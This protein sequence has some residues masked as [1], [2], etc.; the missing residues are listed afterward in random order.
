MHGIYKLIYG[1][2]Y[3]EGLFSGLGLPE[4][5]AVGVYIGE[6]VAPLL[7]IFGFR[8]KIA[9]RLFSFTIVLVLP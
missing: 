4:F 3:I 6:V 5:F 7:L 2:D 8:T 9:A 1:W